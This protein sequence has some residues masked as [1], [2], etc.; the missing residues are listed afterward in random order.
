MA[1]DL[2][3]YDERRTLLRPILWGVQKLIHDERDFLL[4]AEILNS[5]A[6]GPGQFLGFTCDD[7]RFRLFL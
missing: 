7:G 1:V 4:T 3:L 6:V 5:Y 2:Y